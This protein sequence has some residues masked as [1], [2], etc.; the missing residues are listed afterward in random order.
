MVG[1]R[2]RVLVVDDDIGILRTF[3]RIL[4]REGFAVETSENG[5]EALKKAKK[6]FDVYLI[7]VKLPDMEGTE[8]LRLIN[9]PR[10]IKIIITGY[11]SEEVGRKAADYG[12]DD[13]LVKPVNPEELIACVQDR[14]VV[15]QS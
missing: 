13:Y 4:E 10:G 9:N 8:L 3:K 11:S 5:A 14:L 7:D 1:N 2:G 6:K 12:A 15:K